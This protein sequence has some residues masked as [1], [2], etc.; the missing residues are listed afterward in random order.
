M[1]PIVL[2]DAGLPQNLLGKITISVKC[3]KVKYN[4]L[5]CGRRTS[6]SGH[7]DE[8]VAPLLSRTRKPVN[9]VQIVP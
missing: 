1:T 8:L 2:L 4:I 3:N 5:R 9:R 7:E 6:A